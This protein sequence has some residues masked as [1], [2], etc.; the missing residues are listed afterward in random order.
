MV[1]STFVLSALAAMASNIMGSVEPW[2]SKAMCSQ[3]LG[4][5]GRKRSWSMLELPWEQPLEPPLRSSSLKLEL[6]SD[7]IWLVHSHGHCEILVAV[8]IPLSLWMRPPK[9][10][11]ILHIERFLKTLNQCR[12]M[13]LLAWH[14]V[15]QQLEATQCGRNGMATCMALHDRPWLP[16]WKVCRVC[17]WKITI[18]VPRKSPKAIACHSHSLAKIGKQHFSLDCWAHP[19]P[20]NR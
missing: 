2:P 17:P 13:L 16:C 19:K 9:I 1:F 14:G 15:W 7:W 3:C 18:W 8:V 11:H 6:P 12:A 20:N 4:K 10:K 5:I